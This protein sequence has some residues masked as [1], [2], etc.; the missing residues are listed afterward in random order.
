MWAKVRAA[1]DAARVRV[2]RRRGWFG[3]GAGLLAGT[4]AGALL[5]TLLPIWLAPGT[6]LEPGP[7]VILSGKDDSAGGQRQALIEQWNALH[8]RNPARMEELP[9]QADAQRS[10][11]LTQAQSGSQP[12]DIYNLDEIWVAEFAK[13]GYL[14]ALAP[15]DTGGFLT[16]PLSTCRYAGRLWA[17]PFNSDAG[18]LFYRKDL[19]PAPPASWTAMS[20]DIARAFGGS[21]A[22]RDPLLAAGY[23]GQLADYEG[24][25][26][27]ALEAIW[28]A[29]WDVVDSDG[30]VVIDSPQARAGLRWLA[31][32]LE[33]PDPQVILQ[34]SR[35][36]DEAQSTHAFYDHKVV[37]LRMWPVAYRTLQAPSGNQPAGTGPPPFG[38]SRLPGP[39]ALGGQDLAIASGTRRPRAA[40]ALIEFLTSERSQQ[41]LFERGGFAATREIVYHDAAVIEKYAY[42]PV[43]LDAVRSARPRPVTP[44][45]ARFTEVF[46][47][48]VRSALSNGGQLPPNATAALRDALRGY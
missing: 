21:P 45:Y 32:G 1:R 36:F 28:A 4:V 2:K 35:T 6:D 40:Q 46:R 16:A 26:V 22:T 17:L 37:F 41:I 13:A 38:V 20:D 19:V 42:A 25:T 23:A 44:H 30:Q 10:G 29:G 12:V 8:P 15:T 33:T 18:L 11:M 3:F 9:G 5:A 14:R 7:L 27:N 24:L 34:Q 47:Q 39:S 48:L 31:T 43:L